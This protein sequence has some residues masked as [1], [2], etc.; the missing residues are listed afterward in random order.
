MLIG[1]KNKLRDRFV[2]LPKDFTLDKIEKLLSGC[3]YLKDNK[4]KTTAS[5]VVFKS[6]YKRLIM[7]YKPHLGNIL[8]LFRLDRF[9]TI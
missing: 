5:R 7:L 8:K 9:L 1:T 3:R 6:E 2:S 4:G